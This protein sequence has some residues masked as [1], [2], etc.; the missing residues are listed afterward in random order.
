MNDTAQS[1]VAI[2]PSAVEPSRG[3][4]LLD[5][6][7]AQSNRFNRIRLDL[8]EAMRSVDARRSAAVPPASSGTEQ[9]GKSTSFFDGF[10]AVLAA[11]DDV[12]ARMEALVA[13]FSKLF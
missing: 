6:A 8:Q 5:K 10:E 9:K 4:Q 11:N 7:L 12:A 3:Q 1:T 2:M 13:D